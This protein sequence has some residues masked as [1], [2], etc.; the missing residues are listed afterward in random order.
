MDAP[1]PPAIIV[2]EELPNRAEDLLAEHREVLERGWPFVRVSNRPF[3]AGLHDEVAAQTER[4]CYLPSSGNFIRLNLPST[5]L[6]AANVA[7]RGSNEDIEAII[8]SYA[9]RKPTAA[10]TFLAAAP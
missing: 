1:E 3:D 10:A 8:A 6:V 9:E 5:A 4:A 2:T 7:R